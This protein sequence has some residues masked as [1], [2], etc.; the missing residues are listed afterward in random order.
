[1]LSTISPYI[2]W[3]LEIPTSLKALGMTLLSIA[4]Y[5]NL[6]ASVND[7]LPCKRKTA[8]ADWPGLLL[9]ISG[10]IR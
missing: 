7:N 10:G 2:T 8:P 3:V 4:E 6:D 5:V 1:M 9:F